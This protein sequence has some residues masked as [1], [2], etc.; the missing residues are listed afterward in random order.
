VV[1]ETESGGHT[2][3]KVSL[4]YAWNDAY[5]KGEGEIETFELTTPVTITFADGSSVTAT[6]S[7]TPT[8]DA[9][10]EM[11]DIDLDMNSLHELDDPEEEAEADTSEDYGRDGGTLVDLTPIWSEGWVKQAIVDALGIDPDS[12]IWEF[13]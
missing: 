6:L 10:E 11:V 4:N 12:P 9:S 2:V 8:E 5:T 7:L 1:A 13:D 3:P